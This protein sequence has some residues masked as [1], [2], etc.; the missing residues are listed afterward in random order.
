[1]KIDFCLPVY[2]EEKILKDNVLRLFDYCYKQN[3]NFEWNIIVIINASTDNSLNISKKLN[4]Q[5]SKYIKY[6]NIKE[7]GRGQAL[8]KYYIKSNSDIIVYMDVDL[9]V[10][11]NNINNLINPII[12]KQADLCIGSR[13]MPDSKINRSF[14]RELSSQGYNFISKIILKHNFSDMQCGFKAINT[15]V[16]KKI[17]KFIIDKKWFFDTELIYFVNKFNYK[18]KEIP[19]NWEE[20][21]YDQRKSKVNIMKDSYKFFINLIK[22]KIRDKIILK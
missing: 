3:F 6:Y 15:K 5:H 19:V 9:A 13:L 20:N 17:S 21:R 2:N 22:L 7:K 4:K 16:F 18:I 12:S 1:M 8:K 14:I 11:L 10:S